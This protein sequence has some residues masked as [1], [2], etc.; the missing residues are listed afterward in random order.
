M[1][2]LIIT[3][4]TVRDMVIREGNSV[5]GIAEG[6]ANGGRDPLLIG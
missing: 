5:A 1:I 4:S 6:R 3:G 2:I